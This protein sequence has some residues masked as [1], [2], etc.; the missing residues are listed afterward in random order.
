MAST[1]TSDS[2]TPS[3]LSPIRYFDLLPTELLRDI[4]SNLDAKPR[5]KESQKTL[6]SLCLTSKLCRSHAH[7][8]LLKRIHTSIGDYPG[9][10]QKLVENASAGSIAMT[11][12]FH[13]DTSDLKNIKKWLS[14]FIK[15]AT[16]LKEV[17][18]HRQL[19]PLKAFFGSNITTLSLRYITRDLDGADFSFPE[20]L[21]LNWSTSSLDA[22]ERLHF[23]LP[24]LRHLVF[25]T[26]LANLS[27]K[28]LD[29]IGQ[30]VHQLVSLTINLSTIPT[31][32]TWI[33]DSPSISLLYVSNTGSGNPI[34]HRSARRICLRLIGDGPDAPSPEILSLLFNSNLQT[35]TS[36]IR[37]NHQIETLYLSVYGLGT[38]VHPNTQQDVTALVAACTSRNVEV[39]WTQ[40]GDTFDAL[41]PPHFIKKS[42]AHYSRVKAG[43][44]V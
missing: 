35:W 27:P 12:E 17:S 6:L 39:V 34:A 21:K 20:L 14:R 13:F 18:V 7:P 42:E 37:G 26:G 29:F 2:Q 38:N 8:L 11:E 23:S 41:A 43:G 5:T 44:V 30:Y 33:L 4:F 3:N 1:S 16:N 10:L 32:P 28:D 9:L 25:M 40:S 36:L 22:F 31:L 24:R 19:V 15:K